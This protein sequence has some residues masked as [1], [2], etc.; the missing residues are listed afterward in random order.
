MFQ[1]LR[2]YSCAL[3]FMSTMQRITPLKKAN[4]WCTQLSSIL[5]AFRDLWLRQLTMLEDFTF[6]KRI[7]NNSNHLDSEWICDSFKISG[8]CSAR[9]WDSW[10]LGQWSAF[11]HQVSH[12][13]DVDR[14][15]FGAREF[16]RRS[17]QFAKNQRPF[18]R[19][20]NVQRYR[21]ES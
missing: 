10:W 12:R 5:M 21:G 6:W 11:L 17:L 19:F 13:R 16:L 15:R 2:L 7:Q 8:R 20:Q 9:S 1:T 4:V 18:Q 14:P 3:R